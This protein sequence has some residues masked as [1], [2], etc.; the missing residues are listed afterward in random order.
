MK[1]SE[2]QQELQNNQ[3]V[4]SCSQVVDHDAGS[5]RQCFQLTH[6]RWLDDVECPEKYKAREQSLPCYGARD[7]GDQ[8]PCHFIND[9][10]R[11]IFLSAAARFQ[12][13]GRNPDGDGDDN[14]YQDYRHACRCRQM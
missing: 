13:C 5:F 2:V 8:L 4:N 11:G 12:R 6:R 10:L 1:N 3:G 14:K 7:V 9:Y